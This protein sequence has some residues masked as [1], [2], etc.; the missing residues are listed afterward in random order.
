M[1]G[2]NRMGGMGTSSERMGGIPLIPPAH[3]MGGI[4]YYDPWINPPPVFYPRDVVKD[5]QSRKIRSWIK[6]PPLPF[7]YPRLQGGGGGNPR[8]WVDVTF[9][10]KTKNALF[11]WKK[12][13]SAVAR[14]A[15]RCMGWRPS[16]VLT[17]CCESDLP[18]LNKDL[19]APVVK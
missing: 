13:A 9:F 6:P 18:L 19:I 14:P 2:G 5:F 15:T 17:S 7:F 12:L 8:I 16:E 3:S 4:R 10:S 1:N 11:P